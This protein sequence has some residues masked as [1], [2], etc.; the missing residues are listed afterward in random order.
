MVQVQ[1]F[2]ER[3]VGKRGGYVGDFLDKSGRRYPELVAGVNSFLSKIVLMDAL[4]TLFATQQLASLG[5]NLIE[6]RIPKRRQG[7]VARVYFCWS[8]KGKNCAVLLAGEIKHRKAPEMLG[9]A[10]ARLREF[11]SGGMN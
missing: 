6:M 10:Q 5:Q 7:G 8:P 2:P 3:V 4:D 9:V 11:Q 1:W